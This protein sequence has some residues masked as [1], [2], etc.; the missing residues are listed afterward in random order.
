MAG[1]WAAKEAVCKV[2]GPRR[3]R[4]RLARHRDRAAADR[5][6]RR[7]PPRPGGR[8]GR[9]ARDGPDRRLDHATS[10]TT[11]SRSR[12]ASGRP[13]AATSSRPTSRSGSTIASGG[14]SPGSSGCARPPRPAAP[15]RSRRMRRRRRRWRE[16]AD[17]RVPERRPVGF[18]RRRRDRRR[19]GDRA[20]PDA[21][22]PWPEGATQLDDDIVA[23]LLPERPARGHKGSFGKLLVIAGSLDYAGAALLVCRA[24]G[25]AGVGPRDA[26][27]ARVAPAA[28]RGEG[29]RGD[30]DGAARGR[31][32]GGRPGA[33]PRPDPRPRA[34]RAS[35]SGPGLRPGLATAELVRELLAP[36]GERR[37]ADRA[38]R[39]GAPL[40]GDAWT[41]GGRASAGRRS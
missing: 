28:V 34:R 31:R 18:G 37:R 20:R 29:R 13:A 14:S 23:A 11:R 1:R 10:R 12:S 30:D 41:T 15:R 3:P 9:A 35:S 33:G 17:G 4:H 21:E 39:R 26:G 32:R 7:P 27:R 38:R 24:A 25:R 2:L 8:A 6:A 16:R 22:R 40:A 5:P 36:P 19:D